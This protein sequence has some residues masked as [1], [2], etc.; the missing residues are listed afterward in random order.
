MKKVARKRTE[1]QGESSGQRVL[2]LAALLFTLRRGL[3]EFVIEAGMQALDVMLEDERTQLCGE[4]YRHDAERRATRAG[5]A[6]GE[7]VLGGRK[8]R[9]SRPRARTADGGREL[10]LPGWRLF[11][12]QDPLELEAYEK[13]I[14]GVSTRK[15]RRALDAVPP[16]L[17]EFGTSKSAVSRRF[18]AATQR[19]LADWL[20]RDLSGI[21]LASIMIDGLKFGEEHMVLVALGIDSDGKKHVL[22]LHEGATENATACGALLDDL[23]ER[24]VSTQRSM[25]F[26]IDG[27]KALTNAI[28]ARFGKRALLQRCQVHKARN[29]KEHLPKELHASVGATMRQAYAMRDSKKAK[30]QLENLARRL[31]DEYPSAAASVREGLVETLTIIKLG[32][33]APFARTFATT[34]PIENLNGTARWVCR[35]VKRWKGGTMI[36]RWCCASMREAQSRFHRV[37]GAAN[38]MPVL[39]EALAAN[40]RMLDGVLDR[41]AGAE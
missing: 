14:V 7:L 32:L 22:G 30:Q 4:R 11:S 40:D 16:E 15:Y 27:A 28:T 20:G 24:G 29:V 6:P 34:N 17:D 25:L 35:N 41:A 38:G 13:M 19:Q 31:D 23:I 8:V 3:R 5:H 26:V 18:V 21:T 36:L 10:E 1:G 12:M 37:K 2:P 39:L 9:V 33:P